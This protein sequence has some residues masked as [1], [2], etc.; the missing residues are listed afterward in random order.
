[1]LA[2]TVPIRVTSDR[3]RAPILALVN[4]SHTNISKNVEIFTELIYNNMAYPNSQMESFPMSDVEFTPDEIAAA[5]EVPAE[6]QPRALPNSALATL[7]KNALAPADM[8]RLLNITTNM[9]NRADARRKRRLDDIVT[10]GSDLMVVKELLK[11]SWTE[12]FNA[13]YKADLI[14]FSLET[15][16][17]LMSVAEMVGPDG[18]INAYKG[19]KPSVLYLMAQDKTPKDAVDQI[20]QL[21]AD[22]KKVTM[23]EAEKIISG[24]ENQRLLSAKNLIL[25]AADGKPIDNGIIKSVEEVMQQARDTGVVDLNGNAVDLITGAVRENFEERKKRQAEHVESSRKGKAGASTSAEREYVARNLEVVVS[26]KGNIKLPE[27]INAEIQ[28][29]LQQAEVVGGTLILS[30][31]YYKE[32]VGN[33]TTTTDASVAEPDLEAGVDITGQG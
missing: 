10:D 25:K 22:G 8:E 15:A 6:R 18:N 5:V 4:V 13:L 19:L 16:Q 32:V 17:N 11:G 28:M 21:V 29:A 31:Y 24:V 27:D 30:L 3:H 2:L 20:K 23:T 14:D 9:Y 26:P 1:M 7:K 12:W 33:A